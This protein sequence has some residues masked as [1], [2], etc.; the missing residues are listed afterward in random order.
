M[1]IQAVGWV[2]DHSPAR[3]TDRLVL[4]SIAN[5]AGTSPVDG[6]WEAWPGVDTIA[7]EAGLDRARTVQEAMARLI[8]AGHL[9][10]VLNGAPDDRIR[11]DRRPNLYRIPTRPRGDAAPHPAH[12]DGVTPP[13]TPP[14][15]LNPVDN[16]PDGVTPHVTPFPDGVTAPRTPPG[17]RGDAPAG[18]GVTPHDITGCAGA[19]PEPS[20]EPSENQPTP[21][22]EPRGLPPTGDPAGGET[23]TDQPAALDAEQRH[24]RIHDACL[25]L[26]RRAADRA[27]SIGNR[28]AWIGATTERLAGRHASAAHQLLE[29]HP[30]LPTVAL[31][32]LLEP[33][34]HRPTP[35]T[36]PQDRRLDGQQAAARRRAAENMRTIAEQ[37][38]D[39][40]EARQRAA[41]NA[42]ELRDRLRGLGSRRALV[43]PADHDQETITP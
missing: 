23:D 7:R 37:G 32:D 34:P 35:P 42:A 17:P 15:G 29:E 41:D 25:V 36:D 20:V 6:A 19:S 24:A 33:P 13:C 28:D 4:I 1:S 16:P 40:P 12:V 9:E 38:P 31:A 30:D 2:L 21:S 3:G 39:D 5:H 8:D 14:P 43:P 10:R 27:R 18:H 26:A 11:G 22:R